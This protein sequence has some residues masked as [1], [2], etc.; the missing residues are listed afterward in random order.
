MEMKSLLCNHS[1]Q[2]PCSVKIQEARLMQ[3]SCLRSFKSYIKWHFFL[4][5]CLTPCL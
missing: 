5:S 4:R 1:R 2:Q 3:C